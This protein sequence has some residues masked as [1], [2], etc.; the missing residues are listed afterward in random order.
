MSSHTAFDFDV[1]EL[2]HIDG[3]HTLDLREV[4]LQESLDAV[5]DGHLSVGA[6]CAVAFQLHLDD[7]VFGEVDKLYVAAVSLQEGADLIQCALDLFVLVCT[8]FLVC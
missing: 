4:L 8:P 5:L 3:F 6:A 7:P 1:L 2:V